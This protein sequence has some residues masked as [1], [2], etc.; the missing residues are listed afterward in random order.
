MPWVHRDD[1]VGLALFAAETPSFAGPANAVAPGAATNREFT[2][3]LGRVL[4]RPTV[5][6][7]PAFALRL[8]LGEMSE[9]LLAS[10]RAVP[11]AA[12]GAGY[13]FRHP[14][15][16]GALRSILREERA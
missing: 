9:I 1:V 14:G 15:V 6:P 12:L 7:A 16:E 3:A 11:K 4:R 5:L 10:T 2:K 8:L 13:A